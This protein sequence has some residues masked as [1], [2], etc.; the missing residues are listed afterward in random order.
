MAHRPG[1]GLRTSPENTQLDCEL[2]TAKPR[3]TTNLKN[4]N[5]QDLASIIQHCS[6]YLAPRDSYNMSKVVSDIGPETPRIHLH[7]MV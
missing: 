4:L 6:S 5:Y 1:G 7:L 3:D 2:P